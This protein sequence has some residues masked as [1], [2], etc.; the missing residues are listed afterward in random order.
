MEGGRERGREG[1]R[2]GKREGGKERG[3]W[4]EG[5]R[6]GKREGDGGKEGGREKERGER[7]NCCSLLYLLTHY[8]TRLL[9]SQQHL[10]LFLSFTLSL[11]PPEFTGYYGLL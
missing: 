5:G 1:G 3:R 4:R 11:S 6:E 10:S 8:L 2:D 9:S 7:E